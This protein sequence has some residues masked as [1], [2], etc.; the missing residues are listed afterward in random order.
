MP[1][2]V[3]SYNIT[4]TVYRQEPIYSG[5]V[6]QRFASRIPEAEVDI[7]FRVFVTAGSNHF[8]AVLL[9]LRKFIDEK[10]MGRSDTS[11]FD[12]PS[13]TVVPSASPPAPKKKSRVMDLG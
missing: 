10:L 3:L 6:V 13:E 4:P 11:P 2:H 8:E 1:A 7:R 5:E 9:E 12:L